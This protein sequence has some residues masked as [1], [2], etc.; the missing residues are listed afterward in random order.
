MKRSWK[1]NKPP[2]KHSPIATP[3]SQGIVIHT[4]NSDNIGVIA[5]DDGGSST[6]VVTRNTQEM[7]P[8]VKGLYGVRNISSL[9]G[10]HDFIVE[11]E[12]EKYVMGD[13]AKYDCAIPLEMN[14]KTKQ[15]LFFD[16]SV[17]VAI[18]Q[19]GYLQ[20]YLIVSV[21]IRM[22]N[23]NEKS[24]RIK[25]LK[26]THTII[27]NG[28]SKTFFIQE[29][30]VAPETASAFWI[31]KTE[32]FTR[33]IDIGSRTIGYATTVYEN[34]STRFIDTESGTL[35]S[36]G[37]QSLEEHY[38]PQGLGEFIHGKLSKVFKPDDTIY[39]LGGGALDK[40][41]VTTLTK[42]YPNIKVMDNPRMSNAKGMYELGR[43]TYGL[44]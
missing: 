38:S 43:N 19:Y 6:C 3:T 26:G 20:N 15:H 10:K 12:N 30:G 42:Y 8:S 14:S 44:H 33:Y 5:I 29:V 32:G 17:L 1:M 23:E 18:H 34:G 41:L 28:V 35:F 37:I 2:S 36:M 16:L 22:H 4:N 9:N 7:F 31:N 24:G 11:Y 39:L 25:R 27:V 21:P 40:E 13:L